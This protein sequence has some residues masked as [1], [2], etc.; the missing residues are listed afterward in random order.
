[1]RMG[2]GRGRFFT[3]CCVI[4]AGAAAAFIGCRRVV[5]ARHLMRYVSVRF[6]SFVRGVFS[7]FNATW[8]YGL[9]D[10]PSN[11]DAAHG[12]CLYPAGVVR[13]RHHRFGLRALCR[14]GIWRGYRLS[15]VRQRM[16][17]VRRR[18]IYGHRPRQPV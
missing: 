2:K 7:R 10:A 15:R 3:R 12:G 16:M 9:V 5:V 18:V 1:M 11:V 8:R 14:R 4:L 6:G 17:R 13:A